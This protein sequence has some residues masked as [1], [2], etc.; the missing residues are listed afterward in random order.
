MFNS[1]IVCAS[2]LWVRWAS[3]QSTP[4]WYSTRRVH[5]AVIHEERLNSSM[6]SYARCAVKSTD[7]IQ[8]VLSGQSSSFIKGDELWGQM[9][10]VWV[11]P[12]VLMKWFDPGIH[13]NVCYVKGEWNASGWNWALIICTCSQPTKYLPQDDIGLTPWMCVSVFMCHRVCLRR[14][15]CQEIVPKKRGTVFSLFSLH[16]KLF[17]W[18]L[19]IQRWSCKCHFR[20]HKWAAFLYFVWY[21]F[22]IHSKFKSSLKGF[23]VYQSQ[24]GQQ[25]ID[26]K[27]R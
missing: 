23:N 3:R 1:T 19:F 17:Q 5:S 22:M 14:N 26:R 10:F 12:L 16:L 11:S 21:I 25:I 6:S 8:R 4:L 13:E 7:L 9:H 18:G 2:N 20:K 15:Y 27:C 24:I